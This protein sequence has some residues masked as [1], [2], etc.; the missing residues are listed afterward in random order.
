MAPREN[1]RDF[2]PPSR[3]DQY[4]TAAG[5]TLQPIGDSEARLAYVAVTRTRR[6]LYIGGLAWVHDQQ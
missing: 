5:T 3:S 1:R 6:R 4:E 2:T